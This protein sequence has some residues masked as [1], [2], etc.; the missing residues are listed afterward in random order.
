VISER[1]LKNPDEDIYLLLAHE[2]KH[3]QQMLGAAMSEEEMKAEERRAMFHAERAFEVEAIK[4]EIAQ[5]ESFGWTPERYDQYLLRMYP[6]EFEGKSK[7]PIWVGRDELLFRMREE[8]RIRRAIGA[9]GM[10]RREVPVRKHVRR[11]RPRV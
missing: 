5:A 8:R 6:E 2:L 11:V 7:L 3:H 4:V 1:D 9:P 10:R